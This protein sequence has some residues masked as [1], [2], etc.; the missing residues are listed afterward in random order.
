MRLGKSI[1]RKIGLSVVFFW[2]G[3]MAFA[4]Q[5]DSVEFRLNAPLAAET[6]KPFRIEYVTNAEIEEFTPPAFEGV[7]V[8]AGPSRS[9]STV[10]RVVDGKTTRQMRCSYIYMLRV[11]IP[12]PFVVPAALARIAGLE[13]LSEPV[14]IKVN[15]AKKEPGP[16]PEPPVKRPRNP[17]LREI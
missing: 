12:G 17:H 5:P 1:R 14:T 8:L 11:N 13:Y 15:G 10:I 7:E 3:A 4:Q 9:T 16:L 6:G 2:A